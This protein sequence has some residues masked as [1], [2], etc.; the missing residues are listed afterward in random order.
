LLK[1]LRFWL[2]LAVSA[3]FL[4]LLFRSTDLGE[5]KDALQGAEYWWLLP[6]F[7]V[8]LAGVMIR[9][10]RWRTLMMPLR[11]VAALRL[12][13]LMIIGYMANNLIPLRAGELVRAWATGERENVSKAGAFGT[14]AVERLMDGCVLVVLLVVAGS[15]AGFDAALRALAIAAAVLFILALGVF[16]YV[17]RTEERGKRVFTWLVH[18]A[19]K[20]FHPRLEAMA[21]SLI[22]GM[23]SIHTVR[24]LTFVIVTSFA[25]WLVEVCAYL[26]IGQAFDLD[27]GYFDYMLLLAAGN[28]A[29]L[30]PATVGGVGPFEWAAKEVL[31]KAGVSASVAAAYA[32]LAHALVLIPVTFMG[33]YFVWALKLNFGRILHADR[34]IQ[35]APRPHILTP[36]PVK[37]LTPEPVKA[38]VLAEK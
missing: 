38:E 9:C 26:L 3:F 30:I 14:I 25:A 33:L 21:S 23:R 2:G 37:T 13:P 19:P 34:E 7:A 18:L 32:V 10:V 29:V 24:P 12:F 4:A 15:F 27:V 6:A 5:L 17:T 36:E 1:S 31:T 11:E 22:I 8:Y 35:E 20:R 16:I 28:L